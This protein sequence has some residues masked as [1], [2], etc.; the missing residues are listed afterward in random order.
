MSQGLKQKSEGALK[1]SRRALR[2]L[3]TAGDR[4][5]L[6]LFWYRIRIALGDPHTEQNGSLCSNIGLLNLFCMKK[7]LREDPQ[8]L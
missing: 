3:Q 6:S 4:I 8:S 1:N 5:V 2:T 7:H